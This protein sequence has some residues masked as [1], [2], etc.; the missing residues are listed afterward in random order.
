MARVSLKRKETNLLLLSDYFS[1]AQFMEQ[2]D[3]SLTELA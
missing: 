3:L 2:L 1:F